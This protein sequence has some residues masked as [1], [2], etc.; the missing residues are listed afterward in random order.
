MPI[1][2][3]PSDVIFPYYCYVHKRGDGSP[4]YI[5]KGRYS[6]AINVSASRNKYYQAVVAKEGADNIIIELYPVYEEEDA[7]SLEIL[8]IAAYK[9][10]FK[11]CNLTS[12]G[13]GSSGF[14][15]PPIS[16]ATRLR[17]STAQ[18]G[19][20]NSIGNQNWLGKHHT[21]DEKRKISEANNN[22][23]FLCSTL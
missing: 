10:T 3:N 1:I 9:E 7:F 21:D 18:Q 5:G 23:Q 11:L 2:Y 14:S 6:R 8:H 20:T 17:M 16:E 19:N 4:F 15:K 13:E 12:G 22:I